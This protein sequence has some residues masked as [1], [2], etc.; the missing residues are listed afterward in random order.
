MKAIE[1]LVLLLAYGVVAYASLSHPSMRPNA[2]FESG[3]SDHLIAYFL[4]G[5]L[6]AWCRVHR[7][8]TRWLLLILPLYAGLLEL[9]QLLVPGRDASIENFLA[10]VFGALVG[11]LAGRA[12]RRLLRQYRMG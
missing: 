12:A 3:N 5:A 11:L 8:Q 6:T 10:S 7:L 4:L 9:G 1:I 2:G